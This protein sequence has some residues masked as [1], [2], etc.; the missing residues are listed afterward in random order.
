MSND[1]LTCV[2]DGSN[3]TLHYD[4]DDNLGYND[5]YE[6]W[7]NVILSV[8]TAT[9]NI[10]KTQKLLRQERKSMISYDNIAKA[11]YM[12]GPLHNINTIQIASNKNFV[13]M[14][15]KTQQRI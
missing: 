12:K 8:K 11:L 15:F 6:P 9:A 14:K 7:L 3:N 10:N 4:N 5:L 2:W 13:S 1:T